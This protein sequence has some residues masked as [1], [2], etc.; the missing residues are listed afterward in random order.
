MVV[1]HPMKNPFHATT[2]PPCGVLP[3]FTRITR[4]MQG[5]AGILMAV[6]LPSAGELRGETSSSSYTVNLGWNASSS[7]DVTGYRIHFGTVS[8]TYTASIMVENVTTGTVSGLA[9]GVTY[10]FAVSALNASGLESAFSNEVSFKP[11]LHASS[12][13]IAGDGQPVLAVSGLIGS[14]YDIE[15]SE[16]LMDWALIET[17]TMPDGGSLKFSDP[18]AGYYPQRFYRTRRRP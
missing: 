9:E 7:T 4:R 5:M 3:R 12:I 10:Y 18:N 2:G 11:G 16:D 14:Q 1:V 15:A 17:V 8:G 13:R 6:L